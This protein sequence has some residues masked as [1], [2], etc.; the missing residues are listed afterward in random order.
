MPL[1]LPVLV[2]I[3]FVALAVAAAAA[4]RT[5]D[6]ADR[7]AGRRKVDRADRRGA[8]GPAVDLVD[9]SLALYTIRARLGRPTTTRAERRASEE[10]AAMIAQADV[11]RQMRTIPPRPA[12][13]AHL[14]VAG[15]PH[16]IDDDART[17]DD[18][19][20]IVLRRRST[21]P[22][23]LLAAAIGLGV[24]VGIVVAI[25]PSQPTGRVLSATATPALGAPVAAP[26]PAASGPLPSPATTTPEV[27]LPP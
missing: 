20:P 18:G 7:M 15:R 26:L 13:P 22:G 17:P 8:L 16:P 21:L 9:R 14:V 4:R 24:V 6:H 19:P 11:I 25:W 23:E 1:E 3:A 12:R 2:I 27:T 10:R 5:G